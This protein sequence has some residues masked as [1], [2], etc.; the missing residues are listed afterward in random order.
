MTISSVWQGIFG[1]ANSFYWKPVLQ[2]ESKWPIWLYSLSTQKQQTITKKLYEV[3]FIHSIKAS[4]EMV[5]LCKLLFLFSF[6]GRKNMAEV[7]S[8][9]CSTHENHI[10]FN[11]QNLAV[12]GCHEAVSSIMFSPS[13]FQ[14]SWKYKQKRRWISS[15]TPD[16]TSLLLAQTLPSSMLILVMTIPVLYTCSLNSPFTHCTLVQFRLVVKIV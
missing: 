15:T 6:F 7:L 8:E 12:T 3:P 2:C 1:M 16:L 4:F 14:A 11:A 9:W 13:A 5:V 10:T